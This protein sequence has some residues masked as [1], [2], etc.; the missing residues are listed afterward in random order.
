[1][2]SPVAEL[3]E[4]LNAESLAES[5]RMLPPLPDVAREILERLG[6]EFID[7]NEIADI[8]ARDPGISARL[9]A[10]A[11][12]AYFGL[13]SPVTDMREVVNR[14]L[15]PDTVRSLAFA[16]ASERSF[17]LNQCRSFNP[18][19]FWHRA[20]SS[21]S[22]AKRIS[23]VVDDLVDE[24]RGFAYVAGLCHSLGLLVLA[25][26]Y[27]EETSRA[28][29]QYAGDDENEFDEVIREQ[30][31]L[32]MSEVTFALARHW[33]MPDVIV[34]AYRCR[35]ERRAADDLLSSVINAAIKSARHIEKADEQAASEEASAAPAGAEVAADGLDLNGDLPAESQTDL[36]AAALPSQKQREATDQ[37]LNA[38]LG[39]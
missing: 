39:V 35:A 24:Q 3:F 12:S 4:P 26:R 14:V 8:V 15:G 36:L 38:M 18:R 6:D 2:N 34:D 23:A 13:P 9:M 19:R 37:T 7:G 21:A 17:D 28:L 27:P 33:K 22:A 11:N 31:G 25:C 20:L 30:F 5:I 10:L 32:S 29:D 1:M 16:L